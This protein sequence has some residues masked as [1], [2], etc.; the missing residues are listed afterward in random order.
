MVE[1][2][3][4]WRLLHNLFSWSV[5]K[6][7]FSLLFFWSFTSWKNKHLCYYYLCN[8]KPQFSG[9]F[10]TW[11]VKVRFSCKDGNRRCRSICLDFRAW[12]KAASV[13]DGDCP[14]PFLAESPWFVQLTTS[15][16]SLKTCCLDDETCEVRETQRGRENC[17]TVITLN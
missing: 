12:E 9:P 2:R 17:S 1:D 11:M 10:V 16:D 5:I 7:R 15:C 8:D 14:P 6:G 4:R 3:D 13:D